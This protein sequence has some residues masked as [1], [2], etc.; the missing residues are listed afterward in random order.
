MKIGEKVS[1]VME[2]IE[3]TLLE[4]AAFSGDKP[5]FTKEGFRAAIYMFSAAIQDKMWELQ[6]LENMPMEVRVHMAEKFGKETRRLIKRYTDIDT[7]D[8]FK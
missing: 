5:E 6:E 1:P 4:H 3:N 2:E 8:L 7:H